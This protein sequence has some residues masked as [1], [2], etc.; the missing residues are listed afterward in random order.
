[1]KMDGV[2]LDWTVRSARR[3][4]SSFDRPGVGKWIKRSMTRW[5]RQDAKRQIRRHVQEQS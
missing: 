3:F 2:Q 1:M 4:I 5:Q